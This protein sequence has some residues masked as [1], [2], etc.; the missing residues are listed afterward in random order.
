MALQKREKTERRSFVGN[1]AF[2][3]ILYIEDE[4]ANWNVTELHLLGKYNL[5]RATDSEETFDL[6]A[7]EQFDLILLDIQLSGSEY[8][9]IEICKILKKRPGQYIP[10]S[11]K[12]LACE[13]IPVVFVTAYSSLYSKEELIGNAGADEVVTKPVDFTRL[14]LVT[15]R[16]IA[17]DL[18][19]SR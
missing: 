14:R 5:K 15:S 3:N 2:S 1:K 13:N 9:G 17:K 8:D 6:L 10:S 7:K 19:A 11:A 12:N 18:L 16:L 4:D